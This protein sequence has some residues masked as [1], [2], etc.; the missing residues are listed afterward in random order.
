MGLGVRGLISGFEHMGL[1]LAEL[2]WLKYGSGF[3]AVASA[4]VCVCIYIYICT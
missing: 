3:W 2:M 4:V 1:G